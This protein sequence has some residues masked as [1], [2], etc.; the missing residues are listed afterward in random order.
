[1]RIR[2][3]SCLIS[4]IVIAGACTD[5]T[6]PRASSKRIVGYPPGNSL[7][8]GIVDWYQCSSTD[9]GQ[10]W[11]C[12]YERT[13]YNAP[14]YWDLGTDF[15]HSTGQCEMTA[16]A[17]CDNEFHPGGG[18]PYS[19]PRYVSRT[20]SDDA[21]L[22][23]PTC[24]AHAYDDARI[25]AYCAGH[26]PNQ[27]ENANIQAA[28]TRMHQLGS[29]CDSLASIG[30]KLLQRGVLHIFPQS[31]Y[32]FGGAAPTGG[33]DSGPDS[34][35]II[36]QDLARIFYDAAHYGEA[37]EPITGVRY[38]NDLQSSLAHEL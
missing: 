11:Y 8:P 22:P 31:S 30:D 13:D 9:Q 5:L 29:V 7:Q 15:F 16:V 1:M 14:D 12:E 6:A 36:S 24:P 37:K 35:A 32:K 18:S 25:R 3:L 10:T 26:T 33:G 28:L 34:W 2:I 4:C 20:A 17:Y 38:H 23:I 27:T 21:V 19:A